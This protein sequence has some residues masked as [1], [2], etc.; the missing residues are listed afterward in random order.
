M[1]HEVNIESIRALEKRIEEGKGDIIEIKRTRNSLLNISTRIPPEILGYIFIWS[2]ARERTY[3]LNSESPFDGLRKGSHNFLLVC[4]HWL[5]VASRTPELW[6]FWGTTIWEWK[7]R[8]RHSRAAPLDLVLNGNANYLGALEVPFQDVLRD[9][10]MQDRIRQIHLKGYNPGL[11][12]SV[13]SSLTPDGDDARE[14]CIESIVL[15]FAGNMTTIAGLSDFFARLRLPNLRYLDIRG[16][17]QISSWDHLTSQTTRLTALSLQ[18]SRPSFALTTSTLISI[19]AS[20][21]NLRELVLMYEALPGD[22]DEDTFPVPLRHL[23]TVYLSGAC[24]RVFGLL[25]RLELPAMLDSMSLVAHNSTVEDISQTLGP[26][27]RS[28]FRRDIRFQGRLGI[29]TSLS[30]DVIE[31]SVSAAGDRLHQTFWLERKPPRAS[32]SMFLAGPPPQRVMKKLYLDLMALTPREH[33]VYFETTRHLKVPEEL[34]V[35]MPKI[36]T[37][38]LYDVALSDG[39]LQPNPGGLHSNT[40]LF[41]S[42]RYLHL[43]YVGPNDADWNHLKVYL[44]HQTSGGQVISL[45]VSDGAPNMRPEMENEIKDLVEGFTYEPS[46]DCGCTSY[47]VGSN[48]DDEAGN[49]EADL[50]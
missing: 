32:F 46:C 12:A 4:H 25:H 15:H 2:V 16:T 14:K 45:R 22:A 29:V 48:E 42:L 11:L 7:K 43:E 10:I 36:E 34:F 26:Y 3:T 20:N 37:L 40:K 28:H 38:R 35:A 41:P 19:L 47:E 21:P 31:I 13:I 23:N 44:V 5:E 33:V 39:F 18:L 8:Y 24:R 27:M 6:S 17:L 49:G 1:G 30:R 9:R 50:D